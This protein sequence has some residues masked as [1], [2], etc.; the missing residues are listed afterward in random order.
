MGRHADEIDDL[1]LRFAG[2]DDR[3][4]DAPVTAAR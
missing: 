2:G 3:A 1:I 4:R